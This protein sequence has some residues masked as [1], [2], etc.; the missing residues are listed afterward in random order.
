[1]QEFP[2]SKTRTEDKE[3]L[4]SVLRLSPKFAAFDC[5]GTLWSGDVG[6]GFFRWEMEQGLIS[7][8]IANWAKARHKDYR[9][10]LVD[11]DT[12]C[13]EM[14][15]LHAGLSDTDLYATADSFFEQ[16]M[17][18]TIFPVMKT[19]VR[20]LH[21]DG[22]EIWAVSSSNQWVVQV[23]AQHF[24]IPPERTL[25]AEAFIENGR[26]T[27]RLVRVPS[28]PGKPL[29]IQQVVGRVPD[30]AFGNSKW[31]ADMLAMANAGFAVNPSPEL[32]EAAQK[33]GWNVYF[34]E[35]RQN[36]RSGITM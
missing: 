5:D 29:A 1:M 20:R 16:N 18:E 34:P 33:N 24:G 36:S 3:F 9:A 6:E 14:V 32:Q 21:N 7:E 28:G 35:V 13:G 31:D 10:G 25:S 8:E 19:L 27:D 12:M 23:G 4:E 15:T 11:E 26:A 30:A 2:V 17:L 22:C